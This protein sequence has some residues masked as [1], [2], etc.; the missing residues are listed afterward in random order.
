MARLLVSRFGARLHWGKHFP[1]DFNTVNAQYDGIDKFR[2][3]CRQIDPRGVFRNEY[4]SRVL[5]FDKDEES[6]DVPITG[7]V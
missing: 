4:T 7:D 5:G 1:L 3:L 2:E 6:Q